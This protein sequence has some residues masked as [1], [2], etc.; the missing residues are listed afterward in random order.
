METVR[1]LVDW[2]IA[3]LDRAF[4]ENNV[5]Q[6]RQLWELLTAIDVAKNSKQYPV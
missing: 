2:L 3:M 5:T 6:F 4:D 1:L